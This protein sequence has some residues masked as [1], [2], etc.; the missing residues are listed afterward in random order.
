MFAGTRR[1]SCSKNIHKVH[2]Q[3]GASTTYTAS[4]GQ[5]RRSGR[6]ENP[7][8]INTSTQIATIGAAPAFQPL[9]APSATCAPGAAAVAGDTA[10]GVSET[11]Y[12]NCPSTVR[13][14]ILSPIF[15]S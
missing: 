6:Y 14:T 13:T 9:L 8:A 2:T 7:S 10:H 5:F 11:V 3:T 12:E 1:F 15:S 4:L